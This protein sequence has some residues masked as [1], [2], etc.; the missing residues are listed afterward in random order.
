VY[1]IYNIENKS[2]KVILGE[3]FSWKKYQTKNQNDC[4]IRSKEE[5]LY[6]NEINAERTIQRK[7]VIYLQEGCV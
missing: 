5:M 4:P 3:S 2:K 1:E 6:Q 7:L